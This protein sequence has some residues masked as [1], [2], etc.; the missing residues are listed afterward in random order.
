[1]IVFAFALD[2]F[3]QASHRGHRRLDKISL[4]IVI[5]LVLDLLRLKHSSSLTPSPLH[6]SENPHPANGTPFL[7]FSSYH[8]PKATR[9]GN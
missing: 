9:N 7:R 8:P 2:L 5:V 3:L 1:V 6:E 4:A